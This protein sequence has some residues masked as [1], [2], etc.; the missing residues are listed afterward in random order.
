MARRPVA[1]PIDWEPTCDRNQY[2]AERDVIRKARQ[3]DRACHLSNT[4][5][6]YQK[7]MSTK[8]KG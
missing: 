8:L 1:I 3:Q 2:L 4:R 6:A 7:I 5:P